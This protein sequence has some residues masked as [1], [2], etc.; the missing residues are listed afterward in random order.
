[1]TTARR[2]DGSVKN[3]VGAVIARST[4]AH[5]ADLIVV[6]NHELVAS[7]QPRDANTVVSFALER[8]ISSGAVAPRAGH[9]LRVPDLQ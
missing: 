5:V 7:V 3:A 1:M 6:V 2:T 9:G 4:S 8:R